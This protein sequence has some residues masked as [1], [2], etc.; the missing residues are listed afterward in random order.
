MGI[1]NIQLSERQGARAVFCFAG[2]SG[3]GKTLSALLFAW[4]LAGGNAS[5]I[6]FIDT[7]NRR[8]A[9]YSEKLIGKDG[10]IHKFHR[11]DLPP[12][13]SPDRYVQAIQEFHAKGV[14]VLI[15]DS[16][17]HVWEGTGG[18]EEIAAAASKPSIGWMKAKQA[19][20]KFVNA[21]LQCDMHIICCVRAREKTDFKNPKKPI[22]LGIQ[23]ICEKNFMF[24]MTASVM[25]ANEGRQQFTMKCPDDLRPFLGRGNDYITAKDGL[26]V[27][28]WIDGAGNC[29][30]EVEAARNNLLMKTEQGIDAIKQHW[31]DTPEKI[32]FALGNE[33]MNQI[34]ASANSFSEMDQLEVPPDSET[35]EYP[36]E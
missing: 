20:K 14:E 6:G 36:K 26:A 31:D 15:V 13:F 18:C 29:D 11:G 28:K 35:F 16:I 22:S 3:S 27:R 4:G 7:E 25:M 2:P 23:P 19:H 12:P 34:F 1:L 32:R 5:K 10:A 30:A 9:L 8:G 24:E 33:F 17:S 21:L